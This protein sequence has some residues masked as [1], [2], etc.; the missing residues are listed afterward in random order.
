MLYLLAPFAIGFMSVL[1]NAVNKQVSQQYGLAL[2]LLVN[3]LVI[4]AAAG[5][6]Y[7]AGQSA[8]ERLGSFIAGSGAAFEWKWWY[9]FPGLFGFAVIF[10]IPVCMNQLGALTVFISFVTAQVICSMLW[11]VFVD[12]MPIITTKLIGAVIALV[13]VVMVAR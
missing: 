12:G 4:L 9:V 2:V 13:G 7:V 3:A 8:P 10:G 5:A 6:L 1:Q 11:D